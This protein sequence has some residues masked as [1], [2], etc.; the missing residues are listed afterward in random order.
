V[1]RVAHAG[2][3][4]F[5]PYATLHG[6]GALGVAGIEPDGYRPPWSAAVA[7]F[8]GI[9][10]AIFLLLG[11]TRPW[12]MTFPRWVPGL[13]GR[14]VPPFL[15]LTPVWLVAPT[16]AIYGTGGLVLSVL[17]AT[18]VVGGYEDGFPWIGVAASV[19]F[20]G[21]GWA[22]AVAAVSYQRR[23]RRCSR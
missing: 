9:A 2:C 20:A 1:H 5:A 19:A 15:P 8:I 4:A 12:G 6:L 7:F 10:L 11:L 22:L 16:L 3:A 17:I 23:T 21:Y 18:G 13:T 14:R